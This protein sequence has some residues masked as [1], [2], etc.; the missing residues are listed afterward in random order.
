[1]PANL[2]P[3]KRSP[4]PKPALAPLFKALADET[5]LEILSL[6]RGGDHCVCDLTSALDVQQSLLSFHLKT[7][8]DAGL[9]SDRK[10]G[11]W[12]YYTLE[13]AALESIESALTDMRAPQRRKLPTLGPACCD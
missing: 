8:R 11:R 5:R 4:A 2:A 9:V 1:M 12:V 6:L 7:L 13:T 10:E 3:H